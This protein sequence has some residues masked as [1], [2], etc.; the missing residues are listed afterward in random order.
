MWE[1][2]SRPITTVVLLARD[3]YELHHVHRL[4][5]KVPR[6]RVQAF[7]DENTEAY[8]PGRVMTAIATEPVVPRT[9]GGILDYL[10]LWTP[11]EK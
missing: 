4:L 3:S 8:G 6:A 7:Y 11:R 5:E 9:M 10:P 1:E 2:L